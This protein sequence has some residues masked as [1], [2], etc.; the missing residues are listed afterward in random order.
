MD[1]DDTMK[2]AEDPENI[3]GIYNY[4]DA[5][6]ERCLY[7]ARCLTY[8]M[9]RKFEEEADKEK[10]EQE[11]I[12]FWD[13][14]NETLD[15]VEDLIDENETGKASLSELGFD[16]DVDDDD[17][18]EYER[19][20]KKAKEQPISKAAKRYMDEVDQWFDSGQKDG[21]ISSPK[22]REEFFIFNKESIDDHSLIRRLSIAAEIIFYYH[23][24]IWVK[25]NRSLTSSY[26]DHE[27][28]PEFKDYPKDSEGS[29]KVALLGIDQ[30]IAGW[31]TLYKY[32]KSMEDEILEFIQ[33]LH[34]LR[35][36][37]ER[38]FPEARKFHR[39]GFDD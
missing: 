34:Q 10:R 7:T 22:K 30:S 14:V 38:V 28:D 8:K 32:V 15:D 37:I 23:F 11:N 9:H 19:H 31:T 18:Q 27:S 16:D 6:C 17:L 1:F 33:L 36:A 3:P 2:M 29:A 21:I 12:A 4:C 35:R 5:W 24:Q 25:V 13:Q 39:P 20:R 26:D